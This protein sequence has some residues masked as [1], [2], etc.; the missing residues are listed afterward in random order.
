MEGRDGPWGLGLGSPWRL[1]GHEYPS[2]GTYIPALPCAGDPLW[3]SIETLLTSVG[4]SFNILYSYASLP[5]LHI[6]PE[7]AGG[8]ELVQ[9]CLAN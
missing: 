6:M 1:W 2:D 9:G 4:V 3:R 7:E 5:A 8:Q